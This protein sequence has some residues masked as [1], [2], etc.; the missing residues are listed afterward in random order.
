MVAFSQ[1][2]DVQLGN[3]VVQGAPGFVHQ[4]LSVSASHQFFGSR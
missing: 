4:S 3:M 1:L 2:G